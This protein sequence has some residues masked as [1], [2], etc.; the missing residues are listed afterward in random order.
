MAAKVAAIAW[1]KADEEFSLLPGVK[2][3]WISGVWIFATV[4][5]VAGNIL[6]S[7]AGGTIPAK[8]EEVIA[9]TAFAAAAALK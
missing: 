7:A 8:L 9:A 4:G 5:R 1:S 3:E 2:G 6:A